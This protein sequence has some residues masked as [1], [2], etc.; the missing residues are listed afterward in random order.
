MAAVAALAVARAA[1]AQVQALR[2]TAEQQQAEIERV[3]QRALEFGM[4][5]KTAGKSGVAGSMQRGWKKWMKSPLGAQAAARVTAGESP[6]LEDM[7][8]YQTYKYLNRETY[9][10]VGRQGC[11]DSVG[12]LQIPYMLGKFVFPLMGYAGWTGLSLAEA[13]AK[14]KPLADALRDNWKALKVQQPD[15]S[16]EGHAQPKKKWDDQ[17]YFMAQDSCMADILRPNR[18]VARLAVMGFV[19]VTCCRSGSFAKDRFDLAGT[20]AR[21]VGVNVM[22]VD[23]FT[24]ER[25]GFH[26]V[27]PDG[28]VEEDGLAGDVNVV[29]DICCSPTIGSLLGVGLRVSSSS[30]SSCSRHSQALQGGKSSS[31]KSMSSS[32]RRIASSSTTTRPTST[33]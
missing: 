26:M 16:L 21:W 13:K 32:L 8:A 27:M 3:Q 12:S 6:V 24:W 33:R 17:V 23:D 20:A 31:I 10:S 25:E 15:A 30:S 2:P 5:E 18:A 22:S 29:R 1:R 19:R 4:V 11:G 9:S 14:N 28:G 7:K